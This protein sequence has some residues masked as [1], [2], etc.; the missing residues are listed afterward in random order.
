VLAAQGIDP[1]GKMIV[2]VGCG[3]GLLAEEIA[4]LG[5]QVIGVDPAV[6]SI[7]TA[8]K[9]AGL[10]RLDIDYRVGRGEQLPL[11]A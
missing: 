2:D 5:A 7:A 1:A 9:H 4:A 10:A 3:G 6:A 11:G 8:R